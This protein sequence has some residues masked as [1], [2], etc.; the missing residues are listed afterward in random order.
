MRKS[1]PFGLILLWM[2]LQTSCSPKVNHLADVQSANIRIERTSAATDTLI[3]GMITP[4][5][6]QLDEKMNV[7]LGVSTG[8][9]V[10]A[11]PSSSMGN[12]FTDAVL[13][14]TQRIVTDTLDFAIQNFG[15][16]RIPSIPAGDITT[17]K[18]YELMPFDN[19]ICIMKLQ[20]PVMLQLLENISAAGGCPVSSAVSFKIAFGKPGDVL[21]H[22]IP[23][24]SLRTYTIAIPDYMANGGDN[25][26]FLKPLPRY[27]TGVMVR[28]LLI[29]HLRRLTEEKKQIIPDSTMRIYH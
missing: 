9:L 10:K 23:L 27:D 26:T 14:E 2:L 28:D 7:V 3:A 24:D 5:K 17:G 6:T 13:D 22:G 11:R 21:I 16:L 15:G 25:M 29:R 12:W 8:D 18:I 4:Y 19:T 20:Y 1:F